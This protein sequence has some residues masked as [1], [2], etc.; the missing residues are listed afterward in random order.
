MAI[1]TARFL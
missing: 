1:C